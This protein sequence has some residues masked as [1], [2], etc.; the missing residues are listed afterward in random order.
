MVSVSGV[1]GQSGFSLIKEKPIL[2]LAADLGK[3]GFKAVYRSHP[4]QIEPLWLRPEVSKGH[5]E[6]VIGRFATGGSP[7]DGAWLQLDDQVVLVGAAAGDAVSS[8]ATDKAKDAAYQVIAALGAI[9]ELERLPSDYEA[10][11][12]IAIP[13]AEW[14]TRDRI[15]EELRE[16]SRSF[17]F[18]GRQQR[19]V[20]TVKFYL[21]GTGLYVLLKRFLENMHMQQHPQRPVSQRRILAVMLGHRN[22][23]VLVFEEGRLQPAKCHTSDDRGF[24]QRFIQAAETADVR[25]VDHRSL[26]AAVVTGNA[27]QISQRQGMPVDFSAAVQQVKEGYRVALESY[28]QDYV[29]PHLVGATN[30]DIVLGGGVA[31]VMRAELTQYFKERLQVENLYFA[32]ALSDHLPTLASRTPNVLEDPC[33]VQRL[34]DVYGLFLAL[35][36]KTSRGLAN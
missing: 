26:L 22:C 7:Q 9:A 1:T 8:F 30:T 12:A 6:S 11:V 31:Q 19:V 5:D 29:V 14:S 35:V 16:L 17:N 24:W 34:A 15:E 3:S 4:G 2:Y 25:G 13:F 20:L 32:E 18:R 27:Q 36:S 10:V 28:F 33:R 21:E 23:S